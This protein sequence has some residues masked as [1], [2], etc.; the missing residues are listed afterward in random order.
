MSVVQDL[1]HCTVAF[2]S[3]CGTHLCDDPTLVDVASANI[4]RSDSRQIKVLLRLDCFKNRQ[5]CADRRQNVADCRTA[6]RALTYFHRPEEKHGDAEDFLAQ[7][8]V[9]PLP[10]RVY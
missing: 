6:H 7:H 10:T 3:S 9:P 5:G 1:I 2:V 8:A 4:L